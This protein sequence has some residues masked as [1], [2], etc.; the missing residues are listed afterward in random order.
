MVTRNPTRPPPTTSAA[1][2]APEKTSVLVIGLSIALAIFGV[3]AIVF[4]IL[5]ALN[6]TASEPPPLVTDY[7]IS[8]GISPLTDTLSITVLFNPPAASY[9]YFEV[10]LFLSNQVDQIQRIS[11]S[12]GADFGEAKDFLVNFVTDLPT[13]DLSKV[14]GVTITTGKE[15]LTN[16]TDVFQ[17]TEFSGTYF[18]PC[19]TSAI[20]GTSS[21]CSAKTSTCTSNTGDEFQ[22]GT[23]SE[24]PL[25]GVAGSNTLVTFSTPF[26][27]VPNVSS[28]VDANVGVSFG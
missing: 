5:Y 23:V 28:A 25:F 7:T 9:D 10:I 27:N 2:S 16:T 24:T 11:T 12:N 3:A 4:V 1:A 17:P 15:D 21:I 6:V 26:A 22:Q 13:T 14:H 20:C 19:V 8:H 18:Q